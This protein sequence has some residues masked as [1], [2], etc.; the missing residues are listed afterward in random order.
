[1]LL[2]ISAESVSDGTINRSGSSGGVQ[3]GWRLVFL[4]DFFVTGK[5]IV[6][7]IE[8]NGFTFLIGCA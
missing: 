1:L 5:I 6:S 7:I 8:S 4:S 3:L 2:N